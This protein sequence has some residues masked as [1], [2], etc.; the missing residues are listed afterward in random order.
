[1]AE[2]IAVDP[3]AVVDLIEAF[4]LASLRLDD[5]RGRV[6]PLIDEAQ[7][8]LGWTAAAVPERLRN[9]TAWSRFAADDLAWRLDLL[10]ASDHTLLTGSMVIGTVP[11][12]ILADMTTANLL[13]GLRGVRLTGANAPA[14][15]AMLWELTARTATDPTIATAAVEAL[16]PEGLDHLAAAI[17]ALAHLAALRSNRRVAEVGGVQAAT[18]IRPDDPLVVEDPFGELAAPLTRLV[19][20]SLSTDPPRWLGEALLPERPTEWQVVKA[21]L[22]LTTGALST[23]WALRVAHW[24]LGLENALVASVRDL[25]ALASQDPSHVPALHPAQD[26]IAAALL[27]LAANPDAALAHGLDRETLSTFTALGQQ[28]DVDGVALDEALAQF[29]LS[30]SARLSPEAQWRVLR[31]EVLPWLSEDEPTLGGHTALALMTLLGWHWLH[32]LGGRLPAE[33]QA[34]L[35]PGA[36]GTVFDRDR[37][38]DIIEL[39]GGADAGEAALTSSIGHAMAVLLQGAVAAYNAA[40]DPMAATEQLHAF[41]GPITDLLD[42]LFEA[43]EPDEAASGLTVAL[44]AALTQVPNPLTNPVY[45]TLG[46]MLTTFGVTA[47]SSA[48][49]VNEAISSYE[50]LVAGRPFTDDEVAASTIQGGALIQPVAP[51]GVAI[52]NAILGA[53]ASPPPLPSILGS[54]GQLFAPTD[55]DD[56]V[57]FAAAYYEWHSANLDVLAAEPMI[58]NIL[59]PLLEGAA[60]H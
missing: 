58:A 57:A 52:V 10:L 23:E 17:L 31:E 12:R 41:L 28:G 45:S 50:Q 54:D 6:A 51:L 53:M 60:D 9:A 5:Q 43:L 37:L 56:P 30:Y 22:L 36:A 11:D 20:T 42:L 2:R 26:P 18:E 19:G 40:P 16:G 47:Y 33:V 44:L 49:P 48:A 25:S 1:M 35:P 21:T 29:V 39:L 32:L 4:L 55:V 8:V 27:V 59:V 38:V 34:T 46:L 13:A 15:A 14:V 3:D 7:A 24:L